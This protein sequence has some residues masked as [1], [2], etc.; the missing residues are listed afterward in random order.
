MFLIEFSVKLCGWLRAS[1]LRKS[2]VQCDFRVSIKYNVQSD[3]LLFGKL[4]LFFVDH[5]AVRFGGK[6]SFTRL[7]IGMEPAVDVLLGSADADLLQ[8]VADFSQRR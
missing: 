5:N 7:T 8:Q 4:D 2:C 6:F 3:T 1:A